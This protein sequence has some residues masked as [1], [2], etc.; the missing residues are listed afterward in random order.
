MRPIQLR[1]GVF[2]GLLGF[3][4]TGLAVVGFLG[5]GAS[6]PE[7][8]SGGLVC[9]GCNVVLISLDTLR[10][11]HLSAYGYERRTSPVLD[12]LAEDGVLFEQFIQNGGGTL[13][14]HLTMLTSLHPITHGVQPSN[15]KSLA[16]SHQTLAE[17]L[18][19]AG[20]HTAA[21]TDAGWMR[22][23]F[24]FAQGFDV[25]D[26]AAGHLE[27]ILPKAEGFLRDNADRPFFLFLHTYDIHS[28]EEGQP[29]GCP[30]GYEQE[31]W[32]EGVDFDGCRD[33]RCA[34]ELLHW[35]NESMEAGTLEVEELFTSEEVETLRAGYDG[36]IRY[37][38]EQ[39][40]R[41]LD[42]LRELDLYDRTLVI[43]TSDHGEEFLEHGRFLH[44][45][46]GYEVLAHIPLIVKLPYSTLQG[47]RVRHLTAMVDLM[48]TVLDLVGVEGPAEQMQGRSLVEAMQNDAP[49][50]QATH[51]YRVLRT[52]RWKYFGQQQGK[53]Y[54]LSTDP[55]EQVDLLESYELDP[56]LVAMLDGLVAED[57]QLREQLA[58]QASDEGSAVTLS[59]QE[60]REL[61]ALGYLD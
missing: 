26:E 38:D 60:I 27:K 41:L 44:R 10:A 1:R 30:G 22:A 12:E 45:T 5:C 37:A 57:H 11:D 31:F 36:C 2:G 7:P 54:D 6:T 59:E 43:V 15:G 55:D 49:V 14:S 33:G 3:F 8:R 21:F 32:P 46:G 56:R 61:K 34:T 47:Q 13:P 20:Y 35:A 23:K 39:V 24:G 53:L 48:P 28:Q 58:A 25:F 51:L 16:P 17:R 40:G 9:E 18:H 52:E 4:A 29:Y 19:E 42:Q 50:R